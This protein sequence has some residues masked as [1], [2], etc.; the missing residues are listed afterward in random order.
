[1][2]KVSGP[3]SWSVTPSRIRTAYILSSPSECP[4]YQV[5]RSHERTLKTTSLPSLRISCFQVDSIRTES[6]L[7]FAVFSG[8]SQCRTLLVRA[9]LNV[10]RAKML[11]ARITQHSAWDRPR[12]VSSN[13]TITASPLL[14]QLPLDKRRHQ[15]PVYVGGRL[16]VN[17]CH[18]TWRYEVVDYRYGFSRLGVSW[19]LSD[20]QNVPSGLS[21]NW[22]II[23]T[24]VHP[25]LIWCR[26]YDGSLKAGE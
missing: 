14:L 20:I 10:T 4:S 18:L 25:G 22:R 9:Y 12:Y 26:S 5:N 16:A 11:S 3:W 23:S 19:F 8:N 2:D 24:S 7:S 6:L 15:C 13:I 17:E 1:M 21:Y